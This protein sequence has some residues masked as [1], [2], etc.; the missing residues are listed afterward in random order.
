MI[1]G[2]SIKGIAPVLLAIMI[3]NM[4]FCLVYPMMTAIFAS[5]VVV[6]YSTPDGL[7]NFY[8]GLGYLLYPFGMFFGASFLGDL[9]DIWGR[10][11]VLF[12]SILGLL[13]SFILMGLGVTFS[14]LLALLLGRFL[15]GLMAGSQPIAQAAIVDQ[16]TK[17]TKAMNMSFITFALSI[18]LTLGPLIGSFASQ[19]E[20][21]TP[22]Y[23][24]GFLCLGNLVWIAKSFH[25]THKVKQEAKFDYLRPIKIFIEAYQ[26]KGVG[27]LCLAFFLMQIGFGIY[28]PFTSL[29]LHKQFGYHAFGLGIFM[30]WIGLIFT[31]SLIF[32]TRWLFPR[33]KV[34]YLVTFFLFLTAI[35]EIGTAFASV[36]WVF[37]LL[38]IPTAMGDIL[39]YT[40]MLTCFSDEAH[41]SKQG[42]AMG[43]AIAVVAVSWT[44]SGFFTNLVSTIGVEGVFFIGGIS[45][46]A[47]A[48][49]M[50]RYARRHR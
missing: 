49:M 6:S 10:K 31:F 42:W 5:N 14:S 38:A 30:A 35:G 4:G 7:R 9:S 28:L 34:Q 3:D 45:M 8:L 48:C 26:H 19:L 15:S 25:E 41:E 16:S 20:L 18:G 46:L 44:I 1:K 43:V 12:I 17:E 24:A 29:Y 36:E 27:Y 40:T 47:S 13:F 50:V 32:I 2:V 33:F 37:W 23:V 22:F 21:S 39:A 11:K